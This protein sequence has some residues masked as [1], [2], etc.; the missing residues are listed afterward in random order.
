M[1]VLEAA[2]PACR[3]TWAR[4]TIDN[5]RPLAMPNDTR[6]AVAFSRMYGRC[7]EDVR[8]LHGGTK[9]GCS[10]VLRRPPGAGERQ[11]ARR[12]QRLGRGLHFVRGVDFSV[13]GVEQN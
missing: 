10:S 9:D 3:G 5:F 6:L 8:R 12:A 4:V 13:R 2:S 7:M 1:V 11:R